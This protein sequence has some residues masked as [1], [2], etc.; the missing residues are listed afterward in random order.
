MERSKQFFGVVKNKAGV[1]FKL[2]DPKDDKD[3]K[4]KR[5]AERL[6]PFRHLDIEGFDLLL[7]QLTEILRSSSIISSEERALIEAYSSLNSR[8]E[9]T[10]DLSAAF[11]TTIESLSKIAHKADDGKF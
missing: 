1:I 7:P 10:T 2:E 4:K 3:T 6:N 9:N 8:G 5:E 11:K